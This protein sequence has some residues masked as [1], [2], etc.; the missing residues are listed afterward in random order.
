MH[1]CQNPMKNI[2][3]HKIVFNFQKKNIEILTHDFLWVK[4]HLTLVELT[5]IF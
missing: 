3:F 4:N 1:Q 5:K 2:F